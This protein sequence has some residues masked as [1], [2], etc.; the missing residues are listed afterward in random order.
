MRNC[1]DFLEPCTKVNNDLYDIQLLQ[2]QLLS[3][4][5]SRQL[6]YPG[7]L[8]TGKGTKST[9][10]A[11]YDNHSISNIEW[12][13]IC[14]S[15][16]KPQIKNSCA[17]FFRNTL[18]FCVEFYIYDMRRVSCMLFAIDTGFSLS[19]FNVWLWKL[20]NFT[21]F[22]P[23]PS[24]Y[25]TASPRPNP[26]ARAELGSPTLAD[27]QLRQPNSANFGCCTAGLCSD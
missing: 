21:F 14:L 26:S 7:K 13:K 19:S 4:V 18:D 27:S 22:F 1:S 24:P 9:V 3:I 10:D 6:P 20:W 8:L 15:Q 16:D 11:T 5:Y 2:L 25:P 23:P 17:L 12:L